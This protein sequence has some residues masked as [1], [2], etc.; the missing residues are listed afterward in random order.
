MEGLYVGCRRRGSENYF[1]K[2]KR[3]HDLYSRATDTENYVDCVI[4]SH[5]ASQAYEMI[6]ISFSVNTFS[7]SVL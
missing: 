7:S 5:Y 1:R 3:R 6:C 2:D 4:A